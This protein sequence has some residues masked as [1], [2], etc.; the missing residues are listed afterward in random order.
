MIRMLRKR[1]A[2]L[3]LVAL[4]PP[5]SA[6]E[7]GGPAPLE[8]VPFD[9]VVLQDAFWKPRIDVNRRVTVPAC[10]DQC[11]VTGRI[12]NF[13]RC[14]GLEAGDHQGA[15]YNDSDLYK[16]LEG[17]AYTLQSCPDAALEARV[18]AIVEQIAAAQQPDGYLNTYWT[19][20]EP[21]KRWTDI[22]HGHELYCAGHL[23]EAGIAYSRAT[24]KRQLLDVAIRLAD[25][26]D[27]EFGP[28]ARQDPPGHQE[29]ELALVKLAQETGAGR[30]REL[31]R[32]FL[33]RRGRPE[34]RAALFGAY[35]QDDAPVREQR[36]IGGHAVRA[37]YQYCAMTDVERA[38]GGA[39]MRAALDALWHDV[40]ERKMYI[41]GG[42]G[43][44]AA[45][46]GFTEA[47]DLP[48]ESA[49]CETC[50]AIGMALWNQ[51]MFLLTGEAK[52]ADLVEREL[53]NGFLAGVSAS[54]D[55]F[56]Y[57][58]PL[59]SPGGRE[60]VPWFDCSCCPT[61]VVRFLPAVGERLYATR[62]DALFVAQ[63]AGSE[64]TVALPGGAVV[65]RQQT[66]YPFGGEVDLAIT[67]DAAREFELNLR[68]PGGCVGVVS[69]RV[70][71]EEPR[72]VNGGDGWLS[73][74]RTWQAGATQVS[75]RLP[76][77][78]RWVRSDPR[79]A[80]NRGR[81]AMMRGPL[82]YCAEAV[83]NG[84]RVHDLV[85]HGS[86]EEAPV[87][88]ILAGDGS[89]HLSIPV[90]R[91][92]SRHRDAVLL[93]EAESAT[94]VPYYQWANRGAGE[95]AVWLAEDAARAAAP[96]PPGELH[97]GVW[98]SASHCGPTDTLAALND[99]QTPRRS[100]DHD[101]PR[102][103]FWDHRGS[104]EWLQYD[105]E[106]P[107]VVTRVGVYWF[108]DTGRGRCRVP[109]SWRLLTLEEGEWRPVPPAPGARHGVA[110]DALQRVEFAPRTVTALRIE[111]QLQ[112][113]MSAGVLEWEVE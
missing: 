95:M 12:A 103:T 84:G 30:Y 16:V 80:A 4:M 55:R 50:A 72:T 107:R 92:R 105:F 9:R 88:E 20:V 6:G 7:S 45:N 109:A 97:R 59:A 43:S 61:N 68:L 81:V 62:G 52:Y 35:A 40:V 22:R 98:V 76:M 74:R 41:T 85:V 89:V 44:S 21:G 86:T 71:G 64:A 33:E 73:V 83:D 27:R 63:Y 54:G 65:I 37:M 75:L 48:N 70:E 77:A 1:A 15:R 110:P 106:A 69:L 38:P 60:R 34:G 90:R 31:A 96:G 79:V 18:D 94:L 47:F 42:I 23:I 93:S 51:R 13:A 28:E 17:V 57:A 39:G 8:A 108:D 82:V 101:L 66:R 100:S 24:G 25:R 29:I 67:L 46:E 2:A 56:F 19:M 26:I 111:V 36:E 5:G 112:P 104:V 3:C 32:F 87:R 53:Y 113:E 11:E 99:G 49:Y 14:A 102:H 10:L 91:V 58:N 78:P